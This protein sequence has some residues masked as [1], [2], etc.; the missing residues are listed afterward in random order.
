MVLA[1]SFGRILIRGVISGFLARSGLS[2]CLRAVFF[3]AGRW[4]MVCGAC[5]AVDQVVV[6]GCGNSGGGGEGAGAGWS[7]TS[8][9][10]YVRI[11]GTGVEQ[12]GGGGD[13]RTFRVG[14]VCDVRD[15]CLCWCWMLRYV[16]I[17]FLDMV[18][19]FFIFVNKTNKQL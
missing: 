15:W 5:C 14:L 12:G 17:S 13:L 19:L 6:V 8:V 10:Y 11:H 7:A 9:L 4:R 1:P 3:S 18:S 2:C 16:E